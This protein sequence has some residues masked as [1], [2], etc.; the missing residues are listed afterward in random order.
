M[1]AFVGNLSR[2]HLPDREP[3][4]GG[5]PFHA[6]RALRLIDTR[7]QLVVRCA[8]EDRDELVLPVARLGSP[9]RYVPGA[10]TASFRIAYDGD[11][12]MMSVESPGD[13]WNADDVPALPH[14]ARWVHVS[15]LLRSDFPAETLA[16]IGRNR[17]LSYDGQGLVRSPDA[18]PL[19]LDAD[20]DPRVL[21]HV[22]V[23]KLS[24]EEAEV[25]GDIAALR[26]P[27]VI[28]TH[29]SKGA[30]VHMGDR[31]ERLPAFRID[32][33]P[34]GAGD[35]FCVGYISARSIGLP[36]TAAARVATSTV[37]ELL[38]SV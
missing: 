34:T 29:G 15:P 28:V 5:G 24:E 8:V 35:A 33:D 37:A 16:R 4:P 3:V 19:R 10:A 32:A 9:V 21:E 17:H 12:R 27:E 7:A 31:T 30:T 18:G 1:I 6:A 26:V 22:Q 14:A 11:R 38:G 20:F 13:T 36:P 2:D 25:V 23:L